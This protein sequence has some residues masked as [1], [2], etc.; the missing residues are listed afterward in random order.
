[1]LPKGKFDSMLER[2]AVDA[3]L[4]SM[5]IK[6]AGIRRLLPNYRDLE[7]DYYR[8]TGIFPIMHI[9]AIKRNLYE[10]HPWIARTL[11]KAFDQARE[12]CRKQLQQTSVSPVMMPW[13]HYY[14][15]EQ[16]QLLGDD[17]WS[18]GV[19]KNRGTL[20]SFTRYI[21]GQGL[22]SRLIGV[23]EMFVPYRYTNVPE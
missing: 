19:D 15:E 17:V 9:L 22:T 12:M 8:R 5:F 20:E 10:A 18:Y 13:I 3:V 23:D 16:Q 4:G 21:Y 14:L 1:M 11:Y 6:G 2:G 7:I